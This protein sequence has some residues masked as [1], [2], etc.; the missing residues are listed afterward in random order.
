[1]NQFSREYGKRV[2]LEIEPGRYPVAEA[3]HL[4][5]EV[6]SKKETTRVY[7]MIIDTGFNH[8]IR[9][10]MYGSWHPIRVISESRRMLPQ[11]VAGYLC[12][13]G[14][15]FTRAED[16]TLEP[17]MLPIPNLGDLV[18]ISNFGAYGEAMSSNYNS[19]TRP[20]SVLVDNGEARVIA[21]AETISDLLAREQ[22]VGPDVLGL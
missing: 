16:E 8:L 11:L 12:E 4:L 10:A 19:R 17:R 21:R 13:S 15:I 5:A 2:R 3:G 7:F 22:H 1:M 14:D 20:K 6:I 9:T 18:V